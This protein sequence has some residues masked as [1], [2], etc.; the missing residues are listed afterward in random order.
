MLSWNPCI[1]RGTF[2]I[3]PFYIKNCNFMWM[4]LHDSYLAL[5]LGWSVLNQVDAYK[6]SLLMKSPKRPSIPKK[7]CFG[8]ILNA[9]CHTNF[10]FMTVSASWILLLH[11]PSCEA[12][13]NVQL[14]IHIIYTIWYFWNKLLQD[15]LPVLHFIFRLVR[16]IPLAVLQVSRYKTSIHVLQ[17]FF[18]Q[19][20]CTWYYSTGN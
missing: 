7:N 16:F 19:S 12:C 13:R 14:I 8:K 20:I 3:S 5:N 10:L 18:L 15:T 9:V 17:T 4:I 11:T 1:S 2:H 6:C